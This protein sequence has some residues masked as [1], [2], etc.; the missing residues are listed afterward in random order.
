MKDPYVE[1]GKPYRRTITG[2]AVH[3]SGPRGSVASFGAV[4]YQAVYSFVWRK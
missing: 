3:Q 2:V 4:S 1:M